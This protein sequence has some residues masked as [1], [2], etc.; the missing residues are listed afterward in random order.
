MI[1]FVLHIILVQRNLNRLAQGGLTFAACDPQALEIW[2]ELSIELAM[3]WSAAIG[4]KYGEKKYAK[5][6]INAIGAVSRV[7]LVRVA[8]R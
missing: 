6:G 8:A 7:D 2:C 3:R 1:T 5:R 4:G